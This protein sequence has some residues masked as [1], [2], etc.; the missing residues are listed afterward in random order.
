MINKP[1][2]M[3]NLIEVAQDILGTIENRAPTEEEFII[4][5]DALIEANKMRIALERIS[6]V[7]VTEPNIPNRAFPILE[8]IIDISKRGL[9]LI[10]YETFEVDQRVKK[11][12]DH[13]N[14]SYGYIVGTVIERWGGSD[15][16]SIYY[17][18][19]FD[20]STVMTG[21]KNYQLGKLD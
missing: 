17:K 18:V 21:L 9:N 14:N 3:F 6:K 19:R 7:M 16:S 1:K 11:Y 2:D 15:P 8:T 20:D 10:Q 12:I 4:I 13:S 5:R